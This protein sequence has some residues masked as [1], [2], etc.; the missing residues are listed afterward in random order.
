MRDRNK[1]RKYGAKPWRYKDD[2]DR[3]AYQQGYYDGYN[4]RRDGW[5]WGNGFPTAPNSGYGYQNGY[6]NGYQTGLSYGQHDRS[7]GKPFR[8]TDSQAYH[9]A[10]RGYMSGYGSKD[11]YRQQ[12]RQGYEEGYQRGYNRR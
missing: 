12:F 11:M 1:N 4:G 6:R 5:K 2:D 9:D 3:R 8:P 7:V 10:D